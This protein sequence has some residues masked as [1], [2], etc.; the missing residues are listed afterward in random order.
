MGCESAP[1]TMKETPLPDANRR[2]DVSQQQLE[3]SD[4]HRGRA[5]TCQCGYNTP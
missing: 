4:S 1:P 2:E 5:T 3:E